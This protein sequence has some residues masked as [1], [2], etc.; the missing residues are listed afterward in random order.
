MQSAR[1]Y[2]KILQSKPI[3]HQENINMINL[4]ACQFYWK[5]T[6]NYIAKK[7]EYKYFSTDIKKVQF[8]TVKR[9]VAKRKYELSLSGG[10]YT[11]TEPD[12]TK[13]EFDENG[14]LK[15]EQ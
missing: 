1:A 10:V 5:D 11:L 3:K 14:T 13:C 8:N 9:L 12:K 4:T 2:Q 15:A 7:Y 6:N